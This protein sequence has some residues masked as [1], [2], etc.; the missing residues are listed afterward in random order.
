MDGD[1]VQV[2]TVLQINSVPELSL[3]RTIEVLATRIVN[4]SK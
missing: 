4:I 3:N 2:D 1:S